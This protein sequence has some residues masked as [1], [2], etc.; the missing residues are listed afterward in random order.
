MLKQGHEV[1]C[2][3][4]KSPTDPLQWK[5]SILHIKDIT[6]SHAVRGRAAL[7]TAA[8]TSQPHGYKLK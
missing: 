7:Q 1:F 4:Q 2:I 5:Q 6:P 8:Y 3:I